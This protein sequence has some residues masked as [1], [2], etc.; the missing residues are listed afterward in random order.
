MHSLR[1]AFRQESNLNFDAGSSPTFS[2]R[3]LQDLVLYLY[4]ATADTET[5]MGL[6]A[7]QVRY[8]VWQTAI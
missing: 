3:N 2:L 6:L 7:L 1:R 5:I 4:W 8:E